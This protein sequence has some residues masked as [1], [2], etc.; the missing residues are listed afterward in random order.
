MDSKSST[1]S[2]LDH[3]SED[4]DDD[5]EEEIGDDDIDD[6][7]KNEISGSKIDTT[8]ITNPSTVEEAHDDKK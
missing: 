4:G 2:K 5:D 1:S 8:T 7:H 3:E 6:N